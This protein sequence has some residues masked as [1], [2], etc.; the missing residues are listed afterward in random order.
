MLKVKVLN[1]SRHH[2][3]YLFAALGPEKFQV[4]PPD[5][6]PELTLF[7][8]VYHLVASGHVFDAYVKQRT[9]IFVS[10]FSIPLEQKDPL[11]SKIVNLPEFGQ[12][13]HVDGLY[14]IIHLE[15]ERQFELYGRQDEKT[16]HKKMISLYQGRPLKLLD[17]SLIAREIVRFMLTNDCMT[18]ITGYGNHSCFI[19]DFPTTPDGAVRNAASELYHA[20]IIDTASLFY[21][22]ESEIVEQYPGRKS[23]S[24]NAALRDKLKQ[25]LAPYSW[26]KALFILPNAQGLE[27]YL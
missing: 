2:P 11:L 5:N 14:S 26:E 13:G 4:I 18:R 6:G 10:I 12:N 21:A 24:R 3:D 27:E 1:V 23:F 7:K 19:P 9:S 22:F 17:D 20:G 25:T 15:K 8:D 16:H